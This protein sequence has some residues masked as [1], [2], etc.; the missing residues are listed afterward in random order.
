MHSIDKTR[1]KLTRGL[2]STTT[3]RL[4]SGLRVNGKERLLEPAL[5]EI[6]FKL[7]VS[8][9]LKM[10]QVAIHEAKKVL[11]RELRKRIA[12]M[13]DELKLEESTSIVN[14]VTLYVPVCRVCVHAQV[15]FSE[16]S[17]GTR[18]NRSIA[19]NSCKARRNIPSTMHTRVPDFWLYCTREISSSFAI[20]WR[21]TLVYYFL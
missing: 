4:R 9:L 7:R 19:R 20:L 6:L 5:F 11:R 2:G 10:A 15:V 18:G 12:E 1:G 21:H 8:S 14:K 13:S 17:L 16:R 3:V